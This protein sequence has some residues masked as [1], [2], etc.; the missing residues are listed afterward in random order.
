[1]NIGILALQGDVEEHVYVVNKAAAELGITAKIIEVKNPA[2]LA[3]LDG[4]ILPGGESTTMWTLIKRELWAPL[5]DLIN[6]GTPVLATCA[7]L[8]LL[9]KKI[10]GAPSWQKGLEV[11]DIEAARN[12]FGRQR[13]SFKTRLDV[14]N[15]G[16]IDAVFI[17][18]PAVTSVWGAAEP[19]ASLRH[20]SLGMVHVAVR[21]GAV[22]ATAFHPELTTTAFHKYLLEEAKR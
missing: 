20:E 18:A 10:R 22:L 12:A 5:R 6:S 14:R 8:I 15:F 16:Q 9:A 7:G 2:D 11:L 3:N 4:L 1:M 17:R 19:L 21:Q 13:E